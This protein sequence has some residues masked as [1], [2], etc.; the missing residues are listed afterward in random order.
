MS[1]P[2]MPHTILSF[3]FIGVQIVEPPALT[4]MLSGKLNL[5]TSPLTMGIVVVKV[6]LYLLMAP[7]VV[8]V[9]S[10]VKESIFPAIEVA[11]F[12]LKP[13]SIK[14]TP[15]VS[16]VVIVKDPEGLNERWFFTPPI[17]TATILFL[18]VIYAVWTMIVRSPKTW[19][20]V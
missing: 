2:E 16:K 15:S 13:M 3:S 1:L 9:L 8:F 5:S 4:T 12:F 14:L 17:S 18:G 10:T 20:L 6:N 11:T 7:L 19:H